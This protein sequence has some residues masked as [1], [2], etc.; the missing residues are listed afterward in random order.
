MS[1]STAPVLHRARWSSLRATVPALAAGLL[2]LGLV[3]HQEVAAAVTVWSTSTAYNHCFLVLPIAGWLAWERRRLL[4][5]AP[6]RPLA[7]AALAVIPVSLAWLVAE[8]LGIM[9]G[10][11][12]MAVASVELLFLAV[13]GWRLCLLLAAPLLYLFFL[14]PFGSFLTPWLQDF[15]ANFIVWGLNLIGIPNFSDG[16][17]IEIPEGAFF[18]AEACAGLR[19]L[20][21]SVAFG[22]LYAV[23]FYTSPWRRAAFV[24]AS[25]VI[26]VLANGMRALGI[27]A[28]GH[29]LG[30]AEAA[31]ADHLIYG[32]I[33]FSFVTLILIVV[34]LPFR[35][36]GPT[37][38][39]A[40]RSP[41]P[42]HAAARPW[43]LA[44]AVLLLVIL[45][46]AGPLLAGT[47]DHAAAAEPV[48]APQS[49]AGCTAVDPK[50][51]WEVVP[52][53]GAAF[54]GFRCGG[55]TVRML[56]AVF[57]PRTNPNII[58]AMQRVLNGE[59]I[60]E[61]TAVHSI[62]G[63][64]GWQLVNTREPLATSAT[65]VWLDG[66]PSSGGLRSRIEQAR[67]SLSGAGHPP[68]LV[69]ARAAGSGS[70]EQQDE[71]LTGFL[72][73]DLR[74]ARGI[75]TQLGALSAVAAT[76]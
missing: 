56:V 60:A 9:E 7:W 20:I 66:R 24:A 75:S 58:L 57:P 62:A 34:G 38:G 67:N 17:T 1:S 68:V 13:W 46:A 41:A 76:P 5:D 25:I 23:T 72:G 11:Q 44:L 48:T 6:V 49:L 19:F 21:A 55:G 53:A 14:V 10:R 35:Q 8:R 42:A 15:T 39:N 33:F 32:W 28:A 71:V 22:V 29:W 12:L 27:V 16:N 61:D 37:P 4:P 31:A 54:A 65:T 2:L 36:D 73:A 47:L 18:V 70:L 64:P 74:A 30:S 52:R 59:D 51:D 40:S 43:S 50:S 26:P 69:V 63:A 3:F 45:S